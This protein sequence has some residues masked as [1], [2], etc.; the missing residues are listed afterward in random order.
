MVLCNHSQ[1]SREFARPMLVVHR[2]Y[3]CMQDG[4]IKISDV[5]R[6]HGDHILELLR[7]LRSCFALRKW[8][9]KG[10]WPRT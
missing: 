6:M 9:K 8:Y 2:S 4:L 1:S 3:K 10:G 7:L 5:N